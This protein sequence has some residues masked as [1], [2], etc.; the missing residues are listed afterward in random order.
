MTALTRGGYAPYRIRNCTGSP[1]N[2]WGDSEGISMQ[3][4]A[5]TMIQN[6]E[7]IDWRF[8]DWKTMREVRFHRDANG[9]T[10]THEH[11][12]RIACHI[13]RKSHHQR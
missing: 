11:R 9:R 2:V 13:G 12:N 5:P 3:E 4:V 10:I 1:I 8:E 6:N 7:A